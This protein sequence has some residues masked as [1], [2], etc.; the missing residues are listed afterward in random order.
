MFTSASVAVEIGRPCSSKQRSSTKNRRVFTLVKTVGETTV[1]FFCG[2]KDGVLPFSSPSFSFSDG[3]MD[4]GCSWAAFFC[5]TAREDH[6]EEVVV[7]GG[8]SLSIIMV[9]VYLPSFP[10]PPAEIE[11]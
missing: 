8:V 10:V 1:D 11:R 2:A 3:M 7:G 6:A 4:E 9:A 5:C